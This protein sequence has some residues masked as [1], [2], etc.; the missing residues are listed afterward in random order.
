[1]SDKINK[2]KIL[3]S[4]LWKFL[5]RSV[6]QG[7]QFLVQIVLAR[8]LLPEDY[9]VLALVTIFI[10]LSNVFIQSGFSTSLIQ[11][12]NIDDIDL[13]SV[14]YLSL[15]IS[16]ILYVVIFFTAPF[17]A[18]FYENEQIT[19]ILRVL[20]VILFFGSVNSVQYA[21][22]SRNLIFKKLFLSSLGAVVASG[23][24]GIIMAYYQFGVWALVVQ[25]IVH[26][27]MITFI[28]WITVK[29][30][31]KLLFSI[32]RLKILFSYGW[33]LL[34]AELIN[35]IYNEIRG[36]LIGKLYT[37]AMLGYYNRGQQFPLFFVN[38]IN[39]TIQ[40]IMLP[41]LSSHQD[42]VKRIKDMVRRFI[43]T[44]SFVMFP[45]MTGMAV[46]AEPLVRVL[47]TE[48]WLPAVPFLQIFCAFYA[49]FPIHTANLQAINAL[50]RSDIF[51]KLEIQKKV[52][53]AI[54]LLISLPFGVY[55]L[56]WGAVVSGVFSSFINASP[57]LK[58]LEYSYK[59]Q[60]RDVIPSLILS[61]IMG[62]SV[63]CIKFIGWSDEITLITQVLVG[64]FIYIGMSKL[65]K[66][67][68]YSYL[69]QVIVGILRNRKATV[70]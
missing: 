67:E 62:V 60:L 56:A 11:K 26:Q 25:Q 9:G 34:T 16:S 33:K 30:R 70:D 19:V 53:G 51:L 61:M 15:F 55:A 32:I 43:V 4:M 52:V 64:T 54:I 48:K 41:V 63:Y 68:S 8:L 31:P 50:G 20:S 65:F 42:D 27:F 3:F 59:E 39:G 44:S 14:F 22:I 13:S 21:I 29:W 47:L 5:E 40:T 35:N 66:L 7:I 58:L 24:V 12:K 18:D 17:L 28:L 69:N 23:T 57:N 1:M 49:L 45:M 36:L 46:V 6:T 37:P 10:L 2:S 38:N